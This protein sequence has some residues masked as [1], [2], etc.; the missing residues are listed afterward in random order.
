[1]HERN[2]DNIKDERVHA[3]GQQNQAQNEYDAMERE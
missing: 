1:M 3:V 2:I